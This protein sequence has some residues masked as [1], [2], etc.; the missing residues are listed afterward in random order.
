MATFTNQ[1][2]LSYN[3]NVTNSNIV[4]GELAEVLSITKTA[5]TGEYASGDDLTYVV[6]IINNGNTDYTGL[7]LTDNLGGYTFGTGTLYPLSY[8]EGSIK[9]YVNG[10]L[11]VVAPAVTEGPPLVITGIAVPAKGNVLI[12]YETE[13]T[14]YAPLD[15]EGSITNVATVTGGLTTGITDDEIVTTKQEPYLT[16]SKSISPTT[17]SENGELTYTFVIQNYGNT[18]AVVADSV[19]ITDTFNPILSSI[20]VSY[21]GEDWTGGINYTYDETTGLFSTIAGQVTVPAATYTQD[22]TTG[23]WTIS[24]GSSQLTITGTV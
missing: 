3:G 1:A 17:V 12:I 5:V 24:P 11:Q 7:T 16:I 21:N 4:T 19:V 10:V 13:V 22:E 18:E 6:S 8:V 20:T 9:Y 15:V 14:S 23:V 2:T